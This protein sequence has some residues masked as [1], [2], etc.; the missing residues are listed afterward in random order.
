MDPGSITLEKTKQYASVQKSS[1]E[2]GGTDNGEE[3]SKEEDRPAFSSTEQFKATCL[4]SMED[5]QTLA[6]MPQKHI[7]RLEVL[8]RVRV[9]AGC[10]H[11]GLQRGGPVRQKREDDVGDELACLVG[12][13]GLLFVPAARTLRPAR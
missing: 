2:E 12:A 13:V 1:L 11:R 9:P 5:F 10:A 3:R 8:G 7:T 6:K 4:D